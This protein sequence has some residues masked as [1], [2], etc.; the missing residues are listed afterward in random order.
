MKPELGVVLVMLLLIASGVSLHYC[1][2]EPPPLICGA[3][4]LATAEV[5]DGG[6]LLYAHCDGGTRSSGDSQNLFLEC[7][8]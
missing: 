5:F 7:L 6:W 3:E 1:I 4:D 8:Q 2:A